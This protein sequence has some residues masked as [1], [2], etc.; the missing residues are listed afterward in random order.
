MT[1]HPGTLRHARAFAMPVALIIVLLVGVV[2]GLMF[3]RQAS[4]RRLVERQLWW[5]QEHHARFGVQEVVDAWMTQIPSNLRL[6]D[7]LGENGHAADLI[8]PDGTVAV[9]F[10][11][12]AQG[13]LLTEFTSLSA[14]EQ[15]LGRRLLDQLTLV[16]QG[17]PKPQNRRAVGPAQVSVNSA[18]LDVLRAVC[19]ALLDEG[20]GEMLARE[21]D[22]ERA[23]RGSIDSP[24]ALSEAFRRVQVSPEERA[25]V[26]RAL[27]TRASL[28]YLVVELRRGR[29]GVPVARYG[30]YIPM[31]DRR[32]TGQADDQVW[33]RRTA[34]LTWDDLGVE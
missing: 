25:A 21:I 27:S 2:T 14:S 34:F 18:S 10:L 22:A 26:L 23:K 15:E 33:G 20:R 9:L 7:A 31:F 29:D 13:S 3:E 8:L 19:R 28:Y 24:N 4:Q 12:E 1:V 6:E 17:T 5:Y 30:G 32:R 11:H 16:E